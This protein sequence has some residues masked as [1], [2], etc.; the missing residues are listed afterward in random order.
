M[1]KG[2]RAIALHLTLSGISLFILLIMV[3]LGLE[4]QY[5]KNTKSDFD[6][7]IMKIKEEDYLGLFVPKDLTVF[8]ENGNPLKLS[9][10]FGKP[11]VL[12]FIYYTCPASC[13]P[14]TEGLAAALEKVSLHLG[15]DYNVLTFSFDKNDTKEKAVQFRKSL[16]EK[17]TMPQGSDK[18]VFATASPDTIEALTKSVGFRF[19]YSEQDKVFVHPNVYVFITPDGKISRYIFGLYP[20]DFDVKMAILEAAKGRTGKTPIINMASIACYRY[21]PKIG[22][23][24][25]D[26]PFIF[27][28]VGVGFGVMTGFVVFLYSRKLKKQR[29]IAASK[30]K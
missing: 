13:R 18:W 7:A 2:K 20:L 27:G 8:D 15:Q 17:V 29:L 23:Y 10:F 22:G 9:S 6:P 28:M 5:P 24:T 3:P 14:L 12:S 30:K 16:V 4:A 26:F 19:F 1:M 11:L 25:L 21:D